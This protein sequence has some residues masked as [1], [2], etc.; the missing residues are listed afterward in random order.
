MNRPLFLILLSLLSAAAPALRAQL[1]GSLDLSETTAD[2]GDY[3]RVL[4]SVGSGTKGVPVAGGWDIDGDSFVDYALAAMQAAPDGRNLAGQVF[5]VFG[6]GSMSGELDTLSNPNSILRIIGDQVQETAGSEIWMGDVTGDGKGDLI[7]CRQNHN[8]GG[9]RIGG[10]ALTLLPGGAPLRDLASS[11]TVLDLRS[12]PPGVP[13]V[14]MLGA[15]SPSRL[16]MWVRLGDVTGDGIADIVV[17][18]DREASNGEANSGAVYV[19]R[20]GPHLADSQTVDLA[21]LGS[22]LVGDILRLRPRVGSVGFDFGATVQVADLDGNGKAEVLAAATLNRSGGTLAPQGGTGRG[23]GGS[24]DGTVYILWDDNFAGD[25]D[26]TPDFIVDQGPGALTVIDG[27]AMNQSFGEEIL[28]GRDYDGDGKSDLFVGD[29]VAD[30]WSSIT[31][32]TNAGTAH[33]IYD[34]ALYKGQEFDL[35]SPPVGFTMATLVGPVPGAI[36]GDTALHGDFNND[37]I[38]DLA[39]GSPN[40]DPFGRI[41]AGTIHIALGQNSPWPA[42]VDLMPSARPS[43]GI[44]LFEIY[45]AKGTV[46]GNIGDMLC[47]SAADGDVNSDGVPDL[48]VNEMAGDGSESDDVGNLLLIDSYRLFDLDVILRHGFEDGDAPTP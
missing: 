10:G 33:I 32:R 12:P 34:I 36:A 15:Q 39:I 30:G 31:G 43:S 26:P 1:I 46:P 8:P 27:G 29:L 17:G 11:G 23:G 3:R 22:V 19:I 44:R 16:C 41:G 47:Y 18:A 48:M 21:D 5:L 14:T 40:D 37:G 9:T 4:G 24:P 42:L 13:I 38:D 20:G 25:W 2:T 45:G 6:D 28:G 35:D 7:V